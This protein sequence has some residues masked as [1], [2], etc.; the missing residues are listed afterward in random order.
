MTIKEFFKLSKFKVTSVLVATWVNVEQS[1]TSGTLGYVN[2]MFG[3]HQSLGLEIGQKET[4]TFQAV[5]VTDGEAGYAI[6]TYKKGEMKWTY[7]QWTPIV[8]G[9][10]NSEKTRDYG[11]TNTDLTT[12]MDVLTWN[13]GTV[14]KSKLI[15]KTDKIGQAVVVVYSFNYAGGNTYMYCAAIGQ[16][17][18]NRLLQGNPLNKL[19]CYRYTYPTFW[20]DWYAWELAWRTASYVDHRNEFR[21]H[22]LLNDP[23]WWWGNSRTKQALTA[24]GN[25]SKATVFSAFAAKDG[26]NATFQVELS[27]DGKSMVILSCGADLTKDF[28]DDKNYN[29]SNSVAEVQVNRKESNNRTYV[30]AAFPTGFQGKCLGLL[31]NFNDKPDDDFVL[32][33]GTILSTSD[34]DTERKI[35]EGFAKKWVVTTSN[36]IFKYKEGENATTYQFFNFEPFFLEEANLTDRAAA[37]VTYNNL[38]ILN[39]TTVL[40]SNNRLQVYEGKQVTISFSA[41]DVDNDAIS[42]QLFGN[43]SASFSINNATGVVTYTP[44]PLEPVLIGWA[45]E[46]ERV[47]KPKTQRSGL[48]SIIYVNLVVCPSCNKNGSCNSKTRDKEFEGGKFLLNLCDCW[49]AYTA[50]PLYSKHLNCVQVMN[51]KKKSMAVYLPPCKQGQNCTDLT[52]AQQGNSTI[53]YE[54]GSCPTGYE[55]RNS[56]CTGASML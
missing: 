46:G 21:G 19:C 55:N 24:D 50:I 22:L 12:K 20:W 49:P 37:E 25:S 41:T 40:D 47:F 17:A 42:Y 56:T 29:G 2:I 30:V 51:V 16:T 23:W 44:N 11:V 8:V 6:V 13:T 48:S 32:P 10:S 18:K 27:A 52:A 5:Y 33:D 35:F 54:C 15:L 39:I 14:F 43:V 9:F 36:T 45:T 7:E 26:D 53:G 31:G 3:T 34:T 1:H 4:S 38:P 28:Y